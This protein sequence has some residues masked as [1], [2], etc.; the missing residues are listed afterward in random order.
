[1]VSKDQ[2]QLIPLESL[3]SGFQ[4]PTSL[5]VSN[6]A[7]DEIEQDEVHDVVNSNH[8]EL[9]SSEMVVVLCDDISFGKESVPVVCVVDKEI[10][11]SLRSHESD[12]HLSRP[13]ESFTYVTKPI[14]HQSLD[15]YP[16]V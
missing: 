2:R 3:S 7:S 5:S 6:P 14:V 11:D 10:L 9:D 15:L 8:I 12:E 16:E 13:W 1:M 4:N